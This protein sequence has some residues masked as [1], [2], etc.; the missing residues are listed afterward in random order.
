MKIKNHKRP[1]LYGGLAS[2]LIF[3][4]GCMRVDPVTNEPIG[5]MSELI[6][7]YIVIPMNYALDWLA[8]ITGG[9]AIALIVLTIIIRLII[10]PPTLN[11]QKSMI[12]TQ[13]KTNHVKPVADKIQ[14]LIKETESQSERQ[15]LT[16]EQMKLYREYN[17][18]AGSQL[19][20]CLPLFIQMP[21]FVAIF[22]VIRTSPEIAQT[23]FLGIELGQ[24]SV[25]LAIIVGVIYYLQS[26]MMT[27]NL[28]KTAEKDEDDAQENAEDTAAQMNRS[29][30]LM[31]PIMF[32]FFSFTSP[33]GVALYWLTGG[34]FAIVQQYFINN[35]Y[36][37]RIEDDV[38]E[39][40]KDMPDPEKIVNL[41]EHYKKS[42]AE[43]KR[44]QDTADRVR[45][46]NRQ[47]NQGKQ[48]RN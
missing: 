29:M 4:S 34:L 38:N 40:L 23:T 1:L 14:K 8:G 6:Y 5:W 7:N 25:L 43:T 19:L 39:K 12:A 47:R 15:R 27:N 31:T 37:P 35:Y 30:S 11:Q 16:M 28:K 44:Q 42:M 13:A 22:H 32:F 33:A 21:I 17:I 36:R 9:Y 45:K 46:K 24:R 2:L 48:R 10:L 26:L 3:L 20:G 41:K 18:S